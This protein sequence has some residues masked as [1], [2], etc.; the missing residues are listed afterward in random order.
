MVI[1]TQYGGQTVSDVLLADINDDPWPDMA[2]GRL[3]A[4][5]A[6][7]VGAYVN[8]VIQYEVDPLGPLEQRRILAIADNQ[9]GAIQA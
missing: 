5:N 7:Q 4:T 9:R 6:D 8:K 3:P 2:V 1:D